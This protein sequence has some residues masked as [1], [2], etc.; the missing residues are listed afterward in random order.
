MKQCQYCGRAM[1]ATCDCKGERDNHERIQDLADKRQE[2][3]D[4]G[5][6][7]KKI[8]DLVFGDYAYVL[9]LLDEIRD[10]VGES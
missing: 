3:I 1:L 10:I 6:K 7:L 8:R 5:E 4:A 9:D 2:S